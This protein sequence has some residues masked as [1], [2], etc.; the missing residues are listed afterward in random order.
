M[1]I[2]SN[3]IIKRAIPDKQ[4]EVEKTISGMKLDLGSGPCLFPKEDWQQ[5]DVASFLEKSSHEEAFSPIP[6][7]E[8][9]VEEIFAKNIVQRYSKI[10]IKLALK[11]W[12]TLLEEGGSITL[13]AVDINKAMAKFLQTFEEKYLDEI[14]GKQDRKAN[15]YFYGYTPAILIK[16]VSEAGFSE[17]TKLS[18][19]ADYFN[20]QLDFAIKA[21]KLNK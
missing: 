15:F 12:F 1:T 2:R 5:F 20:P 3:E 6:L 9:S 13:V 17:V 16:L 14:Y 7:E 11:D 19:T 18:P 10:D 8:N 4:E 21:K